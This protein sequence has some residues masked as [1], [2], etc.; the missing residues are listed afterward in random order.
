M[1]RNV[2]VSTAVPAGFPCRIFPPLAHRPFAAATDL[3]LGPSGPGSWQVPSPDQSVFSCQPYLEA[4]W[5]YPHGSSNLLFSWPL[6][7]PP[8]AGSLSMPKNSMLSFVR[9]TFLAQK[10]FSC[11]FWDGLETCTLLLHSLSP[12]CWTHL[13]TGRYPKEVSL[14]EELEFDRDGTRA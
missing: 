11:C 13:S 1:H 12:S 14:R 2:V 6:S 5:Q 4:S 7:Q 10:Q 8:Q 3:S 9:N